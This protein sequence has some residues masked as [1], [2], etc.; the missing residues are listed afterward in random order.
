MNFLEWLFGPI[1]RL[2]ICNGC[3]IELARVV[4]DDYYDG[5]VYW[6]QIRFSSG[7]IADYCR[8]CEQELIE[9]YKAIKMYTH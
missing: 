4:Q 3:G 1:R 2:C 9:K 6:A 8:S 5:K 7:L